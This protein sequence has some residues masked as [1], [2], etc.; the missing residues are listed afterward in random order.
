MDIQENE[1]KT[2]KLEVDTNEAENEDDDVSSLHSYDS[3]PVEELDGES[4]YEL[5]KVEGNVGNPD[6]DLATGGDCGA[7]KVIEIVDSDS[8]ELEDQIP[9]EQLSVLQLQHT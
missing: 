1:E 7:N 8:A 3:V 2:I 6:Q 4:S 5:M 9:S